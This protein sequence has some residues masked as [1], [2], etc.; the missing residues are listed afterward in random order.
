MITF[1]I[2]TKLNTSSFCFCENKLKQI[3]LIIN[4][5][6]IYNKIFNLGNIKFS[7]KKYEPVLKKIKNDTTSLIL[8]D[9]PYVNYEEVS[10][11][12]DFLSC[13]YN[14]GINNFNHRK[15][16]EEISNGK[17]SFI[18]YN[19]H[20]PHLESFSKSREFNYVKKDVIYKNGTVGKKCVEILMFKNRVEK[21][22]KT[23]NFT[24][25]KQIEIKQ[26]S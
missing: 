1:N 11:S 14:Y 5:V 10:T 2:K 26:A 22:I 7:I 8:F 4:K 18:Y 17:C 15:L 23:V 13:S 6:E 21:E 24:N 19:N 20:N 9:P 16:L 3:P 12:E 25:F